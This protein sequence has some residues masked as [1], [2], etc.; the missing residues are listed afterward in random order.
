MAQLLRARIRYKHHPPLANLNDGIKC[1]N[2]SQIFATQHGL[3]SHQSQTKLD[4]IGCHR[5]QT[6]KRKS[7][8]FEKL[9]DRKELISNVKIKD[10][11]LDADLS[12]APH[13][14]G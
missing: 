13:T 8:A 9:N 2:C 3:D 7:D 4:K 5:A 1:Q 14:K 10:I 11:P 12:S 6:S